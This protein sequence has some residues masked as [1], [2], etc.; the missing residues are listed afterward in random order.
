MKILWVKAN[1][2]LPVHSGGDI[3]SFNLMRHLAGTDNVTFLSYYDGTVDPEYEREL[4]KV[5]PGAVC[6]C[7][8]K[9][10]DSM[11]ARGMD[12]LPS[13][14]ECGALCGEPLCFGQSAAALAGMPGASAGR[15]GV[16]LS[17]C[18]D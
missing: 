4:E 10:Q 1:K 3:R 16:R 11:L 6:V 12:Y 18:G 2:I 8:G 7:T 15:S 5:L 17:G 13:V 9:R 14:S